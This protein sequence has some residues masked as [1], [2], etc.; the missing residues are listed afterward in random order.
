M[1]VVG[2]GVA[3][4]LV[5][6]AIWYTVAHR[7]APPV[8]KVPATMEEFKQWPGA[9]LTAQ[10]GEFLIGL[11]RAGKLPGFSA[12]EHGTMHAG[13]VDAH[14]STV[15]GAASEPYPVSRSVHFQKE[16]DTSDYF[17]VVVRESQSAPWKL[18]K[19]WRTDGE[20]RV[21][22]NYAVP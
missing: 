14:G 21:I 16:G 19:A 7:R 22:Q 10:A 11:A 3:M 15:S 6:A 18:Q 13:I 5:A 4:L 20:G 9:S 17:Y 8:P 2:F 12:G 1:K